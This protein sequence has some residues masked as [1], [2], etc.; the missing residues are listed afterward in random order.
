MKKIN[1]LILEDN[2]THFD[3][4]KSCV[5][6]IANN[7][8]LCIDLEPKKND[9]NEF[10]NKFKRLHPD[11]ILIE[12]NNILDYNE[13]RAEKVLLDQEKITTYQEE[14]YTV[15]SKI[16]EKYKN[17]DLF[18]IDISLKNNKQ[19]KLG[20]EFLNFL[21]DTRYKDFNF[22]TI[23]YSVN[24]PD[25]IDKINKTYPAE[26]LSKIDKND[27]TQCETVK[28]VFFEIISQNGLFN[29]IIIK[30]FK[31]KWFTKQ[32][33][34]FLNFLINFFFVSI[35]IITIIYSTWH[36]G[37]IIYTTFNNDKE[38]LKVIEHIFLA[39]IP[40][41]VVLGFYNYYKFNFRPRIFGR[42][43]S[44]S[45]IE[46]AKKTIKLT[47]T[48]FIS[49][50]TSYLILNIID[51]FIANGNHQIFEKSKEAT[52]QLGN[53]SEKTKHI[54]LYNDD[55]WSLLPY[56]ILLFMLMAYLLITHYIELKEKEK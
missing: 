9:Y 47:K 36:I 4:I 20:I 55:L 6:E 5:T 39:V 12:G 31:I 1:I 51:I 35:V 17:I 45:D 41:F 32:I 52:E 30:K 19:D 34:S 54:L 14:K 37:K 29:K 23:I 44:T 48:L 18:I 26:K 15:F 33:Y 24:P 8:S 7:L 25:D 22:H 40:I 10:I 53:T 27:D 56:G 46:D 3:N 2:K 38:I 28:N 50:I 43:V 49:S 21:I 16:I 42:L 13:G 11:E